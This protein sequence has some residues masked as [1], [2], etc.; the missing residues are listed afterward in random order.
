V[1][2][3]PGALEGAPSTYLATARVPP[4]GEHALQSAVVAAFPNVTAIPVREVLAGVAAVL[5]RIA[6]GVRAIA[7]F[8][9]G[10]GLVVMAGVLAA[11]RRQ[12]L[13][14]SVIFRTLFATR[15][16]VARAFAVEYVCLGAT[17]GLGGTALAAILSW[18]VLRHVLDTPWT[19]EPA[20]MILGIG[21]TTALALAVGFLATFRLLGQ[22]PLPVLRNE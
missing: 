9:I 12:R 11:S 4:A 16:A 15:G 7:L 19:F 2:F 3:S 21:L 10:T 17:A 6:L 22:K 1:I 14:E 18:I 13:Y 20:P 8:A 5:D